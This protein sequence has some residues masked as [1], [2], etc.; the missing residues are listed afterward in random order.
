VFYY[1]NF[2]DLHPKFEDHLKNW[3]TI[4]QSVLQLQGRSAFK[5]KGE[6]LRSVLLYATKYRED[7]EGL[8]QVFSQEIWAVCT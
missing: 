4:M 5:C 6:A 3:M 8:I 2:Q 7:F 1:L